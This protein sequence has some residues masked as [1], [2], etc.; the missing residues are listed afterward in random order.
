MC[1]HHRR[2]PFEGVH[3]KRQYRPMVA[4]E[5]LI[6]ILFESAALRWP[7]ALWFSINYTSNINQNDIYKKNVRHFF[8]LFYLS[9]RPFVEDWI[10][11]RSYLIANS[12][13]EANYCPNRN[14]FFSFMCG[15]TRQDDQF[16]I[17]CMQNFFSCSLFLCLHTAVSRCGAVD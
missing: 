16:E 14:V 11:Q 2:R 10:T 7:N 9:L 12:L 8:A 15:E 3:V 17:L 4:Q 1:H 13:I 5:F 6:L